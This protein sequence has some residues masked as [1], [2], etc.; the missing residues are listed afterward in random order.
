[1]RGGRPRSASWRASSS[2]RSVGRPPYFLTTTNLTEHR[3]RHCDR[4]DRGWATI[5]IISGSD[6]S[7]G[8]TGGGRDG[9]GFVT[10]RAA[11]RLAAATPSASASA[12]QRAIIGRPHQ[13]SPVATLATL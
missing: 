4:R 3:S 5:V 12:C 8:S 6:L 1:M 13:P 9:G 11:G 7:V 10:R 2:P